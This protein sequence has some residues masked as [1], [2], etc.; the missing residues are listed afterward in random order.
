MFKCETELGFHA[1]VT[2]DASSVGFRVVIPS[3]ATYFVWH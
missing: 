2:A 1:A 3:E